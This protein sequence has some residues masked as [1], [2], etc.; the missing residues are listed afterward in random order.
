MKTLKSLK[1]AYFHLKNLAPTNGGGTRPCFQ[2]KFYVSIVLLGFPYWKVDI[3]AI[4][5]NVAPT[6]GGGTGMNF[7][8]KFSPSIVLLGFLYWKFDNFG[9]FKKCS[10]HEWGGPGL[11]I[12]LISK[13]HYRSI[14][15]TF[16]ILYVW[17]FWNKK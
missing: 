3:F 10:A 7:H 9:I 12:F 17:W 14:I 2:Q 8:S 6:N 15:Q 11:Y 1:T 16:Y 13:I 4:F 5:K